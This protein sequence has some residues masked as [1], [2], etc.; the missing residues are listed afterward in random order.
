M[1]TALNLGSVVCDVT[2]WL[3]YTVGTTPQRCE[4]ATE[5][6][7]ALTTCGTQIWVTSTTLADLT[8]LLPGV[9]ERALSAR[10]VADGV[11]GAASLATGDVSGL[12]AGCP[13]EGERRILGACARSSITRVMDL[14]RVAAVGQRECE[15]ARELWPRLADLGRN[16]VVAT[17]ESVG[18]S[19]I[20]TYDEEFRAA[21]PEICIDPRSFLLG[22]NG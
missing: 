16:L 10:E 9:L 12:R 4:E 7:G 21:Y 6:I 14:A 2:M 20:V 18:A 17:A 5:V 3:E 1:S 22:S 15:R 19:R 13:S 8:R 11:A